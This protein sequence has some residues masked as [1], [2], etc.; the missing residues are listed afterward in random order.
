MT[1][2]RGARTPA[3]RK[4]S[5]Q[6]YVEGATE[7]QYLN[8]WFRMYRQSIA[9]RVSPFFAGP[10]Q[11]VKAAKDQKR[12]DE[13]TQRRSG[14]STF[15]EYWC[16]FDRDEH[17]N[18]PEA[19]AIASGCGVLIAETNPCLELWFMLH[20]ADQTAHIDRHNAQSRSKS[21]TGCHKSL[22]ANV[23]EILLPVYP[24]ARSRSQS[25]E[26]K[27]RGDGSGSN[28]NPSSDI[29][30]LIDSIASEHR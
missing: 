3:A 23:F 25:L 10:L 19:R 1:P 27:H 24:D 21:L 22:P 29:W 26:V 13:R 12:Q 4:R 11:L 7:E 16:V 9:G 8:H 5:I 14:G 2:G 18:M 20:F 15:D 28:A 6:V 17:P 30:R